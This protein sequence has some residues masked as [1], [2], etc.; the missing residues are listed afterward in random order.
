MLEWLQTI[1]EG[2]KIEEGKL[3]IT[4]VMNAV[5]TE[6]PKNAVPKTEFN[7][8]VKE[9]KAAEGTIAELKKNAGDNTELTEKIK[10]Y[11]EQ[12]KTLQT[13]AANTAKNYA[14]K[15]KLT[16]SGAL[17]PDYLIYKQGGLDK[18]NFD[19]DGNPIGV[20]DVVKPLKESAPH[21]F[22]AENKPNGYDPAGG[23]GSGGVVNPWKKESF[24]LTEQGRLL[25][26]DPVQAKQMA[27]AAGVTLNI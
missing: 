3:D 6:F 21:L 12:I 1:L 11:E 7:D 25:K 20:D 16:E 15:A 9:L 14:L 23:S 13:E 24:N 22:K 18:F 5:R 8:K 26:S 10:A 2:A 27:S 17:D 4:A 19:K